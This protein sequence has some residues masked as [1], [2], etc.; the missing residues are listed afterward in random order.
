MAEKITPR[1][2]DYSQWYIDL[3]TQAELADYAPV[4]GCMIIRPR[5]YAIW[6]VMQ[7]TLDDMFKAEG[8]QNCYFPT[9]I[10]YSFYRK[11]LSMSRAL[12]LRC[13]L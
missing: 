4:K 3:V 13:L 7:R 1:A 5:G 2:E 11:R 9:L 10:P 12:A 8:V 6:E